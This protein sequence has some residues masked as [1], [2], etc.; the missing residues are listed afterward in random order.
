MA[1]AVQ[2]DFIISNGYY[3]MVSYTSYTCI[4]LLIFEDGQIYFAQDT[5]N[6]FPPQRGPPFY[7]ETAIGSY[8]ENNTISMNHTF[9]NTTW[10]YSGKLDPS[11]NEMTTISSTHMYGPKV[12]LEPLH[13]LYWL[14]Q[15]RSLNPE[16]QRFVQTKQQLN[17]QIKSI[18]M[19]HSALNDHISLLE[20]Q[21][22]SMKAQIDALT[23]QMDQNEQDHNTKIDLL[24]EKQIH[25][26]QDI[27]DQQRKIENLRR[28]NER[29]RQ[30]IMSVTNTN[31]QLHS[32]CT[33]KKAERILKTLHYSQWSTDDVVQW[34]LTLDNG[35]YVEYKH[36]LGICM[37]KEGIDGAELKH[38]DKND[39]HR[40]GIGN[41]KHKRL[42]LQHITD[43]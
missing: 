43:L 7:P 5:H 1:Q 34:I 8:N 28:E 37:L 35:A 3:R 12:Q 25:A 10:A 14:A 36:T 38:L 19:Q 6:T 15:I 30:T 41:F 31:K 17:Y 4:A 29:I 23:L 42:I 11:T 39:L 20:P 32:Q 40:L 16:L 26:P 24:N 33:N 2:Q 9:Q 21:I 22:D 18:N 13:H 27:L